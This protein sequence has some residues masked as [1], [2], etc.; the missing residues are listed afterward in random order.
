MIS[1][2]AI[3][4]GEDWISEHY[5]TIDASKQSFQGKVLERRKEWDEA[6][7]ATS[8]RS[9]FTA[10]RR[11]LESTLADLMSGEDALDGEADAAVT[12]LYATQARRRA[13]TSGHVSC[14]R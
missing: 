12:D 7:G 9:Q 14:R 4:V 2:D 6:D 11:D 1:S 10:A 8:V 5:F 13:T 3:V